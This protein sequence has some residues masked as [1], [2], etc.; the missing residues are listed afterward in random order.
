V[1]PEAMDWTTVRGIDERAALGAV[2]KNRI[3]VRRGN[4]SIT[5][6]GLRSLMDAAISYYVSLMSAVQHF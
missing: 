1:F 3:Q 5:I 4:E 6:A 2:E